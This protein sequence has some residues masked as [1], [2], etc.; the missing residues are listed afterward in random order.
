[1]AAYNRVIMVGNLTR[2]PEYRNLAS[3]QGVCRL[4]LASNR[5]FNNRQTGSMVQEVCY[6]DVDV[7]GA[8]AESCRQY[9]QKGRP[10]L[11]EGRLKLD[12]WT[13]QAGQ[14]RS[15]HSIVAERVVFLASNA[16]AEAAFGAPM[17]DSMEDS[18]GGVQLNQNNPVERDLLEQLGKAQSR[19]KAAKTAQENKIPS[20]GEIDFNDEQPFED[21]LPF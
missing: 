11:V 16:S 19:V 10:V 18:G 4:G 5:Q 12:S 21:N 2:D 7:W 13:D 6:V 14:K 8:Q 3:G 17:E 20:T 9:L 1:M 15:K